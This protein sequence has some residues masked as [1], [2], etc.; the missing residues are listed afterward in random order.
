MI[1]S[2]PVPVMTL[3]EWA[4]FSRLIAEKV[5]IA[6]P[7]IA[8]PAAKAAPKLAT[9]VAGMGAGA[10]CIEHGDGGTDG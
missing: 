9:V 10:D 6:G 2:C 8:S 1:A 3:A 4:G 7:R 5:R